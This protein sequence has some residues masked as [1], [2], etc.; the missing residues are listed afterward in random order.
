[1]DGNSIALFALNASKKFGEKVAAA[2]DVELSNHEERNFGDGEHKSRSLVN[3][4]NKR[5]F[6][7]YSLFEEP[8]MSVNDKL[9]RLLFFTGALKDASAAEVNLIIPYLCYARKDRKTKPRDPVTTR[10]VA[11]LM[12]AVG[13][14]RIL[15]IDVHNL[16]AFQNAF[17]IRTEH[18]EAQNLL[19]HHFAKTVGHEKLAVLSPD[20]GGLKRAEKFAHSLHLALDKEIS[21][22]V[23]EKRRS[24]GIVSGSTEIFGD[25]KDKTVIIVD[26]LISSGTTLARAAN[27]C[28]AAGAKYILAAATHGAFVESANRAL[29]EQ[30]IDKVVITNSIPPFQLDQE[31]L[32]EKIH[33]LDLAPLFAEAIQRIWQGRSITELLAYDL[34]AVILEE[35]L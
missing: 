12:E 32:D 8:G 34:P 5:V 20:L 26:D 10:Y 17:R 6:V 35:D 13:V 1:M 25:V 21:F 2:L 11:T 14:D 33:I 3:V 4:R 29:R 9:C 18:L 16:Q 24:M 31:L 22:A 15:T 28:K 23:M 30:A 27:A 19:A 7:I